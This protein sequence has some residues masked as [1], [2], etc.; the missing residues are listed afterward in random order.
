MP[1]PSPGPR[2]ERPYRRQVSW[3]AG[4]SSGIA[5]PDRRSEGPTRSSG[6]PPHGEHD[7]F[8]HRLQLQGQPR[9]GRI[10]S[11]PHSHLNPSRG[12]GAINEDPL[13]MALD[14]HDTLD[15]A[16]C[17]FAY[18]ATL[19]PGRAG[20]RDRSAY[21]WH[22]GARSD[23][24]IRPD[25]PEDGITSYRSST[26]LARG[27]SCRCPLDERPNSGGHEGTL[28]VWFWVLAAAHCQT[29]SNPSGA[30]WLGTS[31]GR[32]PRTFRR[33]PSPQNAHRSRP[34]RNSEDRQS[35]PRSNGGTAAPAH[36]GTC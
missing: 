9:I 6:R 13:S 29:A 14:G 11:A 16:P 15:R 21:R 20:R 23:A 26:A 8:A 3:L 24:G 28:T 5:F 18:A 12:T 1:R 31:R 17:Q 36:R 10:T 32:A 34:L 4:R 35:A 30:I 22:S 2:Q 25:R 19:L 7:A 27:T 33:S